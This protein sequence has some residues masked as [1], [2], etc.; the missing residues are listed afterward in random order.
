MRCPDRRVSVGPAPSNLAPSL[1]EVRW[2]DENAIFCSS[3][4]PRG[5]WDRFPRCLRDRRGAHGH[6]TPNVVLTSDARADAE[7]GIDAGDSASCADFEYFPETCSDEVLCPN[8]PSDQDGAIDPRTSITAVRGRSRTDVWVVGAVGNAARFDGT[9]RALHHVQPAETI[10]ALWLRE[11][12]E[13]SG[14]ALERLFS[15]GLEVADGGP[16]QAAPGPR[17]IPSRIRSMRSG[18]GG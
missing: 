11:S 10:R 8:W 18:R 16:S 2:H 9:N 17:A 15:R 3:W 5:V 4:L 6:R 12:G 14:A 1:T 13:I 7:T